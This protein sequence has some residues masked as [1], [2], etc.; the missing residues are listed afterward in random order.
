M[1][2]VYEELEDAK[3]E[4][5]RLKGDFDHEKLKKLEEENRQLVLSLDEANIRV[6]ALTNEAEIQKIIVSALQSRFAEADKEAKFPKEKVGE[7]DYVLQELEDRCK[8]AEDELKWKVE[9]FKHLEEAH[10]KL[11]D[12][13]QGS[14]N[15]WETEKSS[16]LDEVS[17]LQESLDDGHRATEGFKTQLDMCKQALDHEESRR[18]RVEI[19]V[20]EMKL[21]LENA[22]SGKWEE[23]LEV[24]CSTAETGDDEVASLRHLLRVKEMECKDLEYKSRKLEMENRELLTSIRELQE[25]HIPRAPVTQSSWVKLRN[26][27]KTLEQTHK[28]CAANL[29]EKEADWSSSLKMKDQVIEE[30]KKELEDYHSSLTQLKLQNEELSLML[31]LMRSEFSEDGSQQLEMKNSFVV[32]VQSDLEKKCKEMLDELEE[33]HEALERL[34]CELTEKTHEGSE[35]EFEVQVWKS[36]AERLKMQV[37]ESQAMRRDLEA[38]LLAQAEVEEMLR[39]DTEEKEQRIS[40]LEQQIM[41]IDQEIMIREENSFIGEIGRRSQRFQIDDHVVDE[42]DDDDDDEQERELLAKE[43]EVAILDHVMEE[44]SCTKHV[45]N[46]PDSLQED[47]GRTVQGFDNGKMITDL[48]G[49]EVCSAK[50]NLDWRNC[51]MTKTGTLVIEERSPFKVVN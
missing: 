46:L 34:D 24:E 19:Q 16:L 30:L 9:Q 36:I 47:V 51:S 25:A 10:E 45:G 33:V 44:R 4:I 31:Q 49:D 48:D 35:L 18:K 39:L 22:S 26:K 50:E 40:N 38:S 6:N 11:R 42:E 13:F 37:E 15:E 41:L 12:Q 27:L 2:K 1:D 29:R 21:L 17:K 7:G 14:K 23:K 3:A 8:K 20:S 28:D 32:K 5:E 43:L